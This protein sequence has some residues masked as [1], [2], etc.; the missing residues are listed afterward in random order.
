MNL[1]EPGTS[2]SFP[3]SSLLQSGVIDC[4]LYWLIT[5]ITSPVRSLNPKL[6]QVSFR[7]FLVMDV[8]ELRRELKESNQDH[9]LQ[10]WDSLDEEEQA[11]FFK[12]LRDIDYAKINR[13]FDKTM[14][15]AKSSEKK[16][17][18]LQPVPP[19]KVGCATGTE[20]ENRVQ[21]WRE[22]GLQVIS[23]G[24]VAVLLLAGGQGTRLGV[25]YPKG[26]YDVGLPSGKTLYQ[27]Q[28]ERILRLQELAC[29]HAE[30]KA[31]IPW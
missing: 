8:E 5:L 18:N 22:K 28:A 24:K 23:E 12:D 16:D 19:E 30:N 29:K 21:S 26:M 6:L 3:V 15:E 9:L 14:N 2:Q 11:K 4:V 7:Y 31:T 17:E 20:N 25:P 1:A 13:S 27:L 10:H